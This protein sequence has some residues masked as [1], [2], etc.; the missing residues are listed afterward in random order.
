MPEPLVP[1]RILF[2]FSVPCKYQDFCWKEGGIE[3]DE[4]CRLP[5][6]A[7]LEGHR[8]YSDFRMVWNETGL[9]FSLRVEGKRQPPWCRETRLDES[10]GLQVWIDTRATQN[11]HRASR[12]CHRFIFMPSG[13]G[14][15][16][17][18]PV[19][20]QLLIS[21]AREHAKPVRPSQLGVCGQHRVGG[22]SLSAFVPAEVLTGYDPYDHPRLGFTY[23]VVDRELGVQSFSVGGEF[24]FWDDP[25]VWAT[26]ELVK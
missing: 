22:Y 13:G 19:A 16:R 2:R 18:E 20:D 23:A 10:D 24:P 26:L 9:A 14:P 12:F 25:S 8:I 3:L 11:V 4:S 17:A 7:G 5:D 15:R 6:L 1:A 21:R